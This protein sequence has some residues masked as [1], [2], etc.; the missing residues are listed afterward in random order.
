MKK[1]IITFLFILSHLTYSEVYSC[2]GN[3]N[4]RGLVINLA[5][6]EKFGRLISWYEDPSQNWNGC[7]L[8][9]YTKYGNMNFIHN[10]T[11]TDIYGPAILDFNVANNTEIEVLIYEIINLNNTD[12]SS[13]SDSK[14]S[15]SLNNDGTR[16]AIGEK[17]G[18][19]SVARVYEYNDNTDAW[20]QLGDSVE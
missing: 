10:A 13:A 3:E 8:Y 15:V 4:I 11:A 5:E 18:T 16:L 17:N 14:Y 12:D 19:N 6:G 9:V 20:E 1:I 2:I 7:G